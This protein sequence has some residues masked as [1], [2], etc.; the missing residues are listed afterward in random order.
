MNV[1]RSS[2]QGCAIACALMLLL[3]LGTARAA[4]AEDARSWRAHPA[5]RIYEAALDKYSIMFNA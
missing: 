1:S 3:M 5:G 2:K 4:H